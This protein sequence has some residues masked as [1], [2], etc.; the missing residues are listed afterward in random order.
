MDVQWSSSSFPIL[1]HDATVDR[2]TDGTGT[3][4]SLGLSQLTALSAAA[5]APWSTDPRFAARRSRTPGDFMP[6]VAKA[7]LD[8]LLDI[9]AAPTELGMA[10]LAIY[11]NRAGW[12]DRTLLM[13]TPAWVTSMRGWQPTLHYAV[14]EYNAATTIRR[15]SYVASL[16]AEAYVVPARD[17]DQAD[18]AYWHSYGLK[19]Y[20]WSSDTPAEDVPATWARLAD[21]GCRRAHHQPAGRRAEAA[22]PAGADHQDPDDRAGAD[23]DAALG[24]V[25]A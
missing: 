17:V 7:D 11:I 22:V 23:H 2:T 15:G 19:V 16:G 8:V 5:Y 25:A 1:M 14:I 20:A 12:A 4:S 21:A 10:K 13:G 9:H 3:P 6:A 24:S 18:V